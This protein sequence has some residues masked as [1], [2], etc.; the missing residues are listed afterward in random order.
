MRIRCSR[1]EQLPINAKIGGNTSKAY[2]TFC[3]ELAWQQLSTADLQIH[4]V[5]GASQSMAE[6]INGGGKLNGN[7]S[8][9]ASFR[10]EVTELRRLS[11][12]VAVGCC[13]VGQNAIPA[14]TDL[15]SW[16]A[17][18]AV[19]PA[20]TWNCLRKFLTNACPAR[21]RRPPPPAR[22]SLL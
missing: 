4:A 6:A 12:N 19:T 11:V 15:A 21:C 20:P 16:L 22:F 14:K 3:S 9:L 18:S 13:R 2:E 1:P 10:L 17:F 8:P 7:R 5:Q